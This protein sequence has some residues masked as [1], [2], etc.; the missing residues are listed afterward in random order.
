MVASSGKLENFNQWPPL[1]SEH[2]QAIP[3]ALLSNVRTWQKSMFYNSGPWDFQANKMNY[4][5]PVNKYNK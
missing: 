2:F 3:K 4:N 1:G 5:K